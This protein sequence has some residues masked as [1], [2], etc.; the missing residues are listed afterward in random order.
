MRDD[1]GLPAT[2]GPGSGKPPTAD[3]VAD[4]RHAHDTPGQGQRPAAR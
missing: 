4:C 3:A 2:E 1:P